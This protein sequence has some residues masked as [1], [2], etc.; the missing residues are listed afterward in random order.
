MDDRNVTLQGVELA[1]GGR[2]DEPGG[3]RAIRAGADDHEI[4]A[5]GH[6]VEERTTRVSAVR[7]NVS[8]RSASRLSACRRSVSASMA[9]SVVT[10]PVSPTSRPAKLTSREPRPGP[11]NRNEHPSPLASIRQFRRDHVDL[12]REQTTDERRQVVV[13][14]LIRCDDQIAVRLPGRPQHGRCVTTTATSDDHVRRHVVLRLD[15]SSTTV[16]SR[17]KF[18]VSS[19]Q[20]RSRTR[21][22]RPVEHANGCIHVPIRRVG[23][24][25]GSQW[26]A[27]TIVRPVSDASSLTDAPVSRRRRTAG[28]PER[29]R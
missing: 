25:T 29:G 10:V 11:L 18:C 4:V 8:A 22:S 17:R 3:L 2:R 7:S 9:V 5:V 20:E 16:V 15:L 1:E 21:S 19:S 26:A 14:R 27:A 23:G 24:L 13:F 28:D 12:A 6:L